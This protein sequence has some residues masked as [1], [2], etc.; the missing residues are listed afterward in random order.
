MA[1]VD[2]N[3]APDSK[4]DA[5]E[6]IRKTVDSKLA[7]VQAQL[8]AMN[9]SFA[10]SLQTITRSMQPQTPVTEV[11]DDDFF[12]PKKL[13]E[14]ILAEATKTAQ[15]ML[16]EDRRKNA[17]IYQLA[18]EYPEI[19]TDKSLQK[20]ILEAQK[21]LPKSLQDT[22]DGYELAVMKAIAKQG[23]LP[24]SKRQTV[25]DDISAGGG[26]STRTTAKKEAKLSD[27]T[28]MVAEL[29]R[30]R[31]LTEEEMKSLEQTSKRDSY[32]KYR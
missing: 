7:E 15:E 24:K 4:V 13:K 12:E 17:T 21:A 26:R 16:M 28:I 14:K 32:G 25:D 3:S 5:T 27:K 11:S 2:N 20:E 9:Q 18:Q 19:Q 23:V 6:E 10:N 29:L 22:A 30:G 1:D 8:E 31:A